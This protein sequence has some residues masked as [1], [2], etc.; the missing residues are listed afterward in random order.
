MNRVNVLK[1]INIPS[2]HLNSGFA[3][4]LLQ[5]TAKVDAAGCVNAAGKLGRK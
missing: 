2:M 5:R 4:E 3:M 1:K